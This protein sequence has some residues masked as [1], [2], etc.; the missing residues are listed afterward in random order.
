MSHIDFGR[1]SDDYAAYRPGLPASFYERLGAIVPLRGLQSLDLGTGPGTIALELAACG[2]TVV[3]IDVS[4]EQIATATRLARERHLDALARFQVATAEATA[5]AE[6]AFDLVTAVQ[7]WHWFDRGAAMAEARRVLRPGGI[8]VIVAYA[9]LARHSA[10]VRDT[11]ELILAFNPSWT[12]AGSTGLHPGWIDEVIDGGFQFVESF[13]YDHDE[14]FSHQRWRGRIR[15]CNGVG[16]GGLEPADVVRFDEQ[17]RQLLAEKYPD[18]VPIPH[19]VW[20]VV[21][22]KGT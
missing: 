9:Y 17:L 22:R 20:C 14:V 16:S 2:N 18:P 19:R 5:L 8:L 1:Y 15:T 7:C 6:D 11:E 21:A 12:M 4:P 10:V 13:C 3:G